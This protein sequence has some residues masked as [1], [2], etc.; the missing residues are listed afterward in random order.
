MNYKKSMYITAFVGESRRVPLY[1]IILKGYFESSNGEA[2][3]PLCKDEHGNN[4]HQSAEDTLEIV[5]AALGDSLCASAPPGAFTIVSASTLFYSL[6][7]SVS[8]QSIVVNNV[9]ITLYTSRSILTLLCYIPCNLLLN[10]KKKSFIYIGGFS[11]HNDIC[12]ATDQNNQLTIYMKLPT[13]L[14]HRIW[15]TF[16]V[17]LKK[18]SLTLDVAGLV[19]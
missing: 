2:F 11:V 7:T 16:C 17:L 9:Y 13:Y 14:S 18:F 8:Y 15:T 10:A 4:F 6:D 5:N 19:S 1:D 12:S 3:S